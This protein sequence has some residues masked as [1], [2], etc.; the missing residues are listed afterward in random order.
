MTDS[1]D[2][3]SLDDE[4]PINEEWLE[5]V[6]NSYH[7]QRYAADQQLCVKVEDFA[8]RPG[9]T[10]NESVLSDIVAVVVDYKLL[11]SMDRGR[12]A[13]ETSHTLSLIVKLLPTDPFSRVFVTEAQFDMREISFY[14][15]VVPDLEALDPDQTLPI[16]RC[17]YARYAPATDVSAPESLLVLDNLK[18]SGYRGQPFSLGLTL[19]QARAALT[20]VARLHALT[21]VLKLRDPDARPL[22]ERYPFLFAAERASESYQELVERGMP[23]VEDFLGRQPGM[24][25]VASALARLRPLTKD[26]MTELLAPSGSMALITHTDFWCNNLLF[27]GK[28]EHDD[29]G[30]LECAVL[31]WQMA[32]YSR[33]TNDVALLLLSSLP[34]QLRRDNETELV[35]TY[36]RTFTSTT[37]R[38]GVDVEE[39]HGY[40]RRQL[41]AD[42]R[43]S[44][45]LAIL[46]CI[47]SVEVAIGDPLT[48]QRLVD[49][50]SDLHKDGALEVPSAA[51]IETPCETEPDA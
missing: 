34:T 19:P 16:P 33:P 22:S 9:C 40:D 38:L 49:V 43:R 2:E 20:S 48:E 21:L 24:E 27:R 5:D 39:E 15:K 26:L 1:E 30:E 23:L 41:D 4:S 32:T 46:L 14:T 7:R 42:L 35:D 50:L 13:E 28:G 8:M 17:Y 47:G 36:W 29:Q 45:L 51:S 3:G 11:L 37:A 44:K 6:L 18:T 25:A 31:D 10:T 12:E